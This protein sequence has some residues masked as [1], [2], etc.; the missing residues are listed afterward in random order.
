MEKADVR[1]EQRRCDLS[2]AAAACRCCRRRFAGNLC[3]GGGQSRFDGLHLASTDDDDDDSKFS[4]GLIHT[5]S[6]AIGVGVLSCLTCIAMILRLRLSAAK[7]TAKP[8]AQWRT[9][10]G[11]GVWMR[12]N[13]PTSK[14]VSKM[15]T[16]WGIVLLPRPLLR[17]PITFSRPRAGI[18]RALHRRRKRRR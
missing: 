15:N 13:W 9:E 12:S 4:F 11:H 3:S 8:P 14:N 7:S 5:I 17:I 6:A 1:R 18:Q 2:W 10:R 16:D